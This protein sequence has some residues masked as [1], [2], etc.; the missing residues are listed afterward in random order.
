[1]ISGDDAEQRCA[2]PADHQNE[3]KCSLLNDPLM[4]YEPVRAE[5][6][7]R[8]QE[9]AQVRHARTATPVQARRGELVEV[10]PLTGLVERVLQ[11]VWKRLGFPV[12]EP[13]FRPD[14]E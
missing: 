11:N 8:W 9:A 12:W 4:R 5:Q 2:A 14:D 7:E 3:R 6:R 10:A 13:G 1:V